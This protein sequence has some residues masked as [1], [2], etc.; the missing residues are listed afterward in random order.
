MLAPA[1]PQITKLFQEF[2]AALFSLTG[3]EVFLVSQSPN[4]LA[5]EARHCKFCARILSTVKGR[6]LCEIAHRRMKLKATRG[7]KLS[8]EICFAGLLDLAMPVFADGEHV[9][10]LLGGRVRLD[11]VDFSKVAARLVGLGLGRLNEK[12]TAEWDR[13]PI[14]QPARLKAA[15]T[16]LAVFARDLGKAIVQRRMKPCDTEHDAVRRAKKMVL[17]DIGQPWQLRE[18]S[19]RIGLSTAYF[20]TLFHK[21]TGM[22]FTEFVHRARVTDVKQRLATSNIRVSEAAYAS[23]FESIPHF[24]R[25]FRLYCG[26]SPSGY[27]LDLGR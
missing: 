5:C 27:R 4:D 10:T 19:A 18:V 22:R 17:A 21:T 20:S 7:H 11:A 26:I 1:L 8:R 24:N 3:L 13:T 15:E 6:M 12:L 9:A 14:L 23:G 25:I 16:L 2:Q